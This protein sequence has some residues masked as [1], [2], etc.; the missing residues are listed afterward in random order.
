MN[1][2]EPVVINHYSDARLLA[3]IHAALEAAGID[4]D[5]I[6]PDALAPIEEFH[7][8]G[9]KA[10]E[11]A[12]SCMNIDSSHRILDVGCGIGGAARYLAHNIGCN[13]N[14]IDL[15]P[16]YISV[17]RTLSLATR[18]NG[19]INFE[20]ASALD[21]PFDSGSF[22]AALTLHVAMNIPDRPA[23]YRE[24]ARVLKPGATLCLYDVMRKSDQPLAFPV[25]WA[26]SESVSHLKSPQQMHSLLADAGFE[27]REVSDRTAFAL[28]FFKQALGNAAG[29]PPPLGVHLIMGEAAREKL[30][31]TLRNIEAGCIAP[32]QMLATRNRD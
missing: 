14:A 17:A 29:A 5:R 18:L 20:V 2:I 24:I 7:I 3:R 31:N 15:T 22:D 16:E 8:G 27:V 19:R 32:V 26:E 4:K 1:D 30:G 21:M 28:D 25:P 10:T 9:R 12:V 6:D 23:L 11:Y 13:V